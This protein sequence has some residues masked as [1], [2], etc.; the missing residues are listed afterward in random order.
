MICDYYSNFIEVAR[1]QTV[2]TRRVVRELRPIFARYGLPDVLVTDNGPQFASAEFAVFMKK[3]AIEHVTSSPYYAQSNGKAENAVKTVKRLFSKCKDSGESEYLALLD[4]RNTPSEGIGKSPSQRLMGRR[5]KT[6]LPTASSLLQPRYSTTA[7]TRAIAGMKRKQS[8]YYDRCHRPLQRL[9]QGEAVRMRLP[10]AKT[11]SAGTCT[12]T[13]GPRSYG[14]KIGE[15][16]YRRNRRQ[17]ISAGKRPLQEDDAA[18]D[19]EQS[20]RG[21]EG[22]VERQDEDSAGRDVPQTVSHESSTDDE[23]TATPNIRRSLREHKMPA[24]YNDYVLQ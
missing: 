9:E 10:G 22:V 15:T 17:L 5:C 16:I 20:A 14:V 23:K 3:W 13:M 6:M 1:L 12:G 4:W 8:Y 2:T 24:R 11:W 7:E 21:E 18:S 19:D